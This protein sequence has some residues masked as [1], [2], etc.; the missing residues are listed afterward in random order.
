MILQPEEIAHKIQ[1]LELQTSRLRLRRINPADESDLIEHEMTPAIMDTIRDQLPRAE[2]TRQVA[3]MFEPW[4]ADENSWVAFAV[5][6]LATGSFT[7]L[8][9]FRV[10]S[11]ENQSLELGY[12]LHPD[13]WRRGYATEA[14]LCLMEYLAAE[15]KVRKAVAYCVAENEGSIKV[16]KN[17][18]FVPEG[19]LK[20]HS[21]LGGQWRDEL[22]FGRIL[23]ETDP[24]K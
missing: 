2:V 5:E 10:V 7:G 21:L 4:L 3:G 17:L 23:T 13:F 15:I 6:E 9:F 22:V 12:R 14:G 19:C 20:Q 8:L 18:G 1:K 11:Y 24:E 16:L